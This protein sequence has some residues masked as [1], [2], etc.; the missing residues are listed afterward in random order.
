MKN[1]G[2]RMAS[3][4]KSPAE[5]VPADAV[6]PATERHVQ[7]RRWIRGEH[8][9]CVEPPGAK[10]VAVLIPGLGYVTD[11]R[12]AYLAGVVEGMLWEPES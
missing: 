12:V 4:R 7:A 5:I 9:A 3:P 1:E 11:P 10:S 2:R 6:D 8:G